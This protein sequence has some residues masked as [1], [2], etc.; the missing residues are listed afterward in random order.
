M[1][2]RKIPQIPLNER[3]GWSVAETAAQLGI[4]RASVYN[5][6]AAH[7]LKSAQILGRRVILRSS[8]ESLL[9]GEAR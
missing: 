1:Q 5:L 9:Q 6:L 4:C 2:V 8:V 3:S 7:K